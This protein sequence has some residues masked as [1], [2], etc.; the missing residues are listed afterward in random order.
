MIDLIF[1][2]L[3]QIHGAGHSDM[4][5]VKGLEA[6]LTFIESL[7]TKSGPEIF[8]SFLPGI[9]ALDNIHPLLVHFPITLLVLFFC[10]DT[11]GGLLTKPKWREFA[12]PLLY[13]GTI[14]AIV[15]V[16]AGFQAAYSAPH[17][18]ATHAIMLRHQA[19]GIAVTL[20]ALT[21]SIRRFFADEGFILKKTY[22]YFALSSL[23]IIL[24]TF[25]ADLGGF[26]VYQ[27]GVA[28]APVMQSTPAP[29]PE[30]QHNH[31]SMAH[32][33]GSTGHSHN[34]NATPHT[35]EAPAYQPAPH[36]HSHAGHEHHSH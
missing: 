1:A 15:T 34:H 11:I 6:F 32:G 17:N 8:A 26:M 13:I 27:H 35:H 16:I 4:R 20:I 21:L 25:G 9:A 29:R 36:T 7:A 18:D 14:A 23:L 31:G 30:H 33:H 28:V 24:L 22:G 10:A 12:T 2:M 3:P 5:A 19:F